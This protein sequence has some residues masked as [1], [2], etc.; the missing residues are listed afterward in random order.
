[1]ELKLLF[2]SAVMVVN[3]HASISWNPV[4]NFE[5]AVNKTKQTINEASEYGKVCLFA[6]NLN[7]NL[8][9]W[10]KFLLLVTFSEIFNFQN[11]TNEN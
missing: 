8:N 3:C 1:M 6:F 9:K 2:I 5:N 4:K 11:Q 10:K 7:L